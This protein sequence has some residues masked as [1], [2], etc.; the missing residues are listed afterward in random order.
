VVVGS[1]L[2]LL[3]LLSAG[4][5]PPATA[6]LAGTWSV[7]SPSS[8]DLTELL[9]AF[10]SNGNLQT[11]TYKI[12]NNATVTVPNPVATTAVSG[13][14]VTISSVFDNNGIVFEG[15]LNSDNTVM[16]GNVTTQISTGGTVI[17]INNG[18]ATMTKQ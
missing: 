7:S 17:T 8:T 11:V 2:P 3:A 9:L 6:V 5:T 1:F 13:S 16:D 14:T 10:D 15:T 12:G 4:C 18:P